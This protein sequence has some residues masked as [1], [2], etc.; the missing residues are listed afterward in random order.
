MRHAS[1]HQTCG[2]CLK[3]FR[4]LQAFAH[5]LTL[6]QPA[7]FGEGGRLHNRA[8]SPL[9]VMFETLPPG[10]KKVVGEYMQRINTPADNSRDYEEQQELF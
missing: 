4:N 5:A 9:H 8:L 7:L 6:H 10:L 3:D 1:H 2:R